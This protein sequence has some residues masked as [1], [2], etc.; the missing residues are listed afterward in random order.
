M[1]F[2]SNKIFFI[3]STC[4][5]EG[6]AEGYTRDNY[7][8]LKNTVLSADE[9]YLKYLIT[10]E[11]FHILTRH[12]KDFK[13][14]LYPIIG[15]H[16]INSIEFPDSL[17]DLKVTNPDCPVVDSYITLYEN[18]KPVKCVMAYYSPVKYRGG[19][20]FSNLTLELFTLDEDMTQM[21][22]LVDRNTITGFFEQVGKNTHYLTN[23]EE[24]LAENFAFTILG[25]TDLPDQIIVDKIKIILTNKN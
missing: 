17:K 19:N 24:I 6:G 7:I 1:L 12:N 14:K 15:F 10:H 13:K 11:L 20:L 21:N 25:K 8:I 5:D 22:K 4:T 16:M 2:R 23:P 9:G 3:K 18:E